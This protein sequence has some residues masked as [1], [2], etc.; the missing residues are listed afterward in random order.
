LTTVARKLITARKFRHEIAKFWTDRFEFAA[1]RDALAEKLGDPERAALAWVP[2][3]T[4]P[5]NEEQA[6]T[7]LKLLDVL[8]DNDDVQ[9]VSANFDIADE[10]MERLAS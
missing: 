9:T 5:V 8:E 6:G 4:I 1:V 7:L 2:Q 3:N 10:V